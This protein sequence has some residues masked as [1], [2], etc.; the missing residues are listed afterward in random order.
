MSNTLALR[1]ISFCG[2][3]LLAGFWVYPFTYI[4][5]FII[6][7]IYGYKYAR[8]CMQ[9]VIISSLFFILGILLL[10]YLPV[11]Q[12]WPS[13]QDFHSVFSRQLRVF[14]ASLTGFSTSI[15]ASSYMLQ[16]IKKATQGRYLFVRL[17]LSLLI[18]ELIDIII[19][20]F[21]GFWGIWSYSQMIE[22]II[23]AYLTR[24][25]YEVILYPIV[26]KP[27]I[28]KIKNIEKVDIVDSNFDFNPLSLDVEYQADNNLYK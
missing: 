8:R 28:R 1:M 27:L 15:L 25:L 7:D 17:F 4:L 3:D 14:V 5:N 24:L 18:A 10:L 12:T 21:I 11:S 2:F 23:I 6:S 16:K 22:F 26:T 19:F 20:S 13:Q 9:A